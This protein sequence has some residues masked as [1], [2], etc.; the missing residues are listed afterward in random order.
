MANDIET[1]AT[2][3]AIRDTLLE[4]LFRLDHLGESWI[5]NDLSLVIDRL[6]KALGETPSEEE[7]ERLRRNLFMS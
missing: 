7:V 6:N 3:R 5:A 1:P 2:L 4:Q